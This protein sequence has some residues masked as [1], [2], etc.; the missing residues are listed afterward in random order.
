MPEARIENTGSNGEGM[1]AT[2]VRL[3]AIIEKPIEPIYVQPPVQ[4]QESSQEAPGRE[5]VQ[6]PK[7]EPSP[8][9][10]EPKMII[11]KDGRHEPAIKENYNTTNQLALHNLKDVIMHH[12]A[13]I[14]Y[15]ISGLFIGFMACLVFS[16]GIS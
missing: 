5:I 12:L 8:V 6:A 11:D 4:Q 16:S 1:S 15:F 7:I 9:K 3:A 14:V 10:L 2:A 13:L